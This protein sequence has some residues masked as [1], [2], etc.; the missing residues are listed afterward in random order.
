MALVA[1]EQKDLY[2]GNEIFVRG[3]PATV[4]HMDFPHVYW[5]TASMAADSERHRSC[6]ASG[7]IFAVDPTK[8]GSIPHGGTAASGSSSLSP[9]LASSSPFKAVSA[10]RA[11]GAGDE[12]EEDD[13]DDDDDD[14]ERFT[15][16]AVS[17][18][19]K[20]EQASKAIAHLQE[21]RSPK[22]SPKHSPKNSTHSDPA[23]SAQP[24]DSD[25]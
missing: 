3:Q 12:D 8:R 23:A 22:N 19:L 21:R 15:V 10:L 5:R 4:T 2:A 16:Q 11:G 13:E 1:A 14:F 20:P 18:V 24:P 25:S 6:T 7:Y 9:A 17:A